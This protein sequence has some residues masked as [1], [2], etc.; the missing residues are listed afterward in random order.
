MSY[1][2]GGKEDIREDVVKYI[3][4]HRNI[5]A[6]FSAYGGKNITPIK[7]YDIKRINIGSKDKGLVFWFKVGGGFKSLFRRC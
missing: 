1:P 5:T 3:R 4:D 2:F 7:R 6:L